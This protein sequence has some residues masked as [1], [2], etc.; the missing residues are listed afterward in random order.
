MHIELGVGKNFEK[1]S[2]E[3]AAPKLDKCLYNI[4]YIVDNEKRGTCEGILIGDLNPI[5]RKG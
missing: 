3:R 2:E 5:H 4:L 1:N